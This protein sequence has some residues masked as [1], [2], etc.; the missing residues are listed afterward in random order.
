METRYL[1]DCHWGGYNMDVNYCH[2]SMSEKNN[3]FPKKAYEETEN[4]FATETAAKD[5]SFVPK[6]KYAQAEKEFAKDEQPELR[7]DI[8]ERK[9][10]ARKERAEDKKSELFDD[11]LDWKKRV[12][13]YLDSITVESVK[14]D[15]HSVVDLFS[16]HHT[17]TWQDGQKL[18]DRAKRGKDEDALNEIRAVFGKW[19]EK[20]R[21]VYNDK[22]Y[23]RYL[24]DVSWPR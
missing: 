16:G 20:G 1:S 17:L 23:T 22:K 4:K 8:L 9:Q 7:A 5:A 10:Q 24:E 12:E 18:L 2:N 21:E 11:I 14:K 15:P 3:Y 13:D 19:N 6:E